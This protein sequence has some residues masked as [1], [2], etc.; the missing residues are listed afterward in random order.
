MCARGL[1]ERESVPLDIRN[2]LGRRRRPRARAPANKYRGHA[3]RVRNGTEIRFSG[4]IEVLL[5]DSQ[6]GQRGI[7]TTTV[8]A[9]RQFR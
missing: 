1:Y 4:K 8:A 9:L 3:R 7:V 2:P 5:F 6:S